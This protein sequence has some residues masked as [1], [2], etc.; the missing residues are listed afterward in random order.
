[1]FMCE[2]SRGRKNSDPP[3]RDT[4][5]PKLSASCVIKTVCGPEGSGA[6]GTWNGME[7][8]Q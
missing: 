7:P 8:A 1:M 4:L 3:R 6:R 2:D 5:L